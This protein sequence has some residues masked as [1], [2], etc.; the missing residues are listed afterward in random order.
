MS[1]ATPV[2][3]QPSSPHQSTS[4]SSQVGFVPSEAKCQ[5][6]SQAITDQ[7]FVVCK[8]C[9]VAIHYSC[10]ELPLY[11]LVKYMKENLYRRKF[12][13]SECVEKIH[14]QEYATL[15]ENI[16]KY[17]GKEQLVTEYKKRITVKD[18][19][20]TELKN[21]INETCAER[22]EIQERLEMQNEELRAMQ[23][24]NAELIVTMEALEEQKH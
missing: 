9:E 8:K 4:S 11:E 10:T 6:C 21:R 19:E 14:A 5:K 20:I 13:C 23:S 18:E 7:F 16:K 1:A 3:I 2:T 22:I 24:K 15:K 12:A 17:D